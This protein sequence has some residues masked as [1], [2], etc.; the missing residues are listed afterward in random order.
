MF[1]LND[2]RVLM[3][4][5]LVLSVA[6]ITARL[7]FSAVSPS[8]TILGGLLIF[9]VLS[10]L[11][12]TRGDFFTPLFMFSVMFLG[13]GLGGVYYSYAS[14]SFGKF[15]DFMALDTSST[16]KLMEWGLI[17]AT[18]C[19]LC[20]S[21]GYWLAQSLTK[22]EAFVKRN[23]VEKG[24]IRFF[25]KNYMFLVVPLL[26]IGG[27]YWVYITHVTAGGIVEAVIL[28]QVFPHLIKDAGL[29]TL[30]YQLYYAG[31]YLWILG[32]QIS[33]KKVGWGF[34]L[35]SILGFIICI[36]TGRIMLSLTYLM[37]QFFFIAL[38]N[39]HL[40]RR[41]ILL[42]VAMMSVGVVIYF[43]RILS[44][45]LFIG[46]N[47]GLFEGGFLDEFLFRIIGSGN[48]ADLQQLVII[49]YAFDINDLMLGSTYLD[50]IRNSLGGYLGLEPSSVG[51]M[52]KENFFPVTSGAPTPGAIGEAFV[53]FNFAAPLFMF[54]VGFVFYR[55]H[56]FVLRLNNPILYF[57]YAMFLV[58]FVFMY[59][60]VDS[61]M[62]AN[63]L[64]GVTPMLLCLTLFYGGV[65]LLTVCKSR[66]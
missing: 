4:I 39:E 30:P 12:F 57:V 41:M 3:F 32:I 37:A 13:Y 51:L 22:G 15:V 42:F 24:F 50:T 63:F 56:Y 52:L 59:A 31:I 8:L 35:F 29:S 20:L 66:L 36:T 14:D 60:K 64:W 54:F 17:Y 38:T 11:L 5:F 25:S 21:L 44:N 55:I 6:L 28:F 47:A 43:L 48:V 58:R 45:Y 26:F 62:M 1:V 18:A 46:E 40:K 9:V 49:F 23:T 16:V 33:G 27:L 19:Y 34:L 2:K 10:V 7:S 65:L 61:T 53:N